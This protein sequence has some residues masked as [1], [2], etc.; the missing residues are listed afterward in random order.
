MKKFSDGMKEDSD[1]IYKYSLI[2]LAIT[3]FPPET[4]ENVEIFGFTVSSSGLN[5]LQTVTA[6][7]VV[8]QT[9]SFLASLFTS[10]SAIIAESSRVLTNIEKGETDI[11]KNIHTGRNYYERTYIA[12]EWFRAAIFLTQTVLPILICALCVYFTFAHAQG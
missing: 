2:N 6:L 11:V 3:F 1:R 7:I 4:I 5:I 12:M 10:R 9:V 8:V